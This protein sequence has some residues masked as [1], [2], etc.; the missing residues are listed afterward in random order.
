MRLTVNARSAFP[1]LPCAYLLQ[2]NVYD[3]TIVDCDSDDPY[4]NV[5]FESFTISACVSS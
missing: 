2:L 4:Q 3:R 5:S 1:T